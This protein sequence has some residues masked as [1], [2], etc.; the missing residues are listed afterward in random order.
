MT[1]RLAKTD[2]T[3]RE[4]RAR[5]VFRSLVEEQEHLRRTAGR[6]DADLV[7]HSRTVTATAFCMS[8]EELRRIEDEGI[9]RGWLEWV[10]VERQLAD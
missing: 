9:R 5:R 4:Y 1:S 6:M 3:P 8:E 2:L 10:D 7:R